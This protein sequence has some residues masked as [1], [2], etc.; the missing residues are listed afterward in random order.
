PTISAEQASE[1]ALANIMD[2]FFKGSAGRAAI[3]LLKRSEA[4]ISEEEKETIIRLIEASR[5]R[6]S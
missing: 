3:A 2:T 6:G 5:Q 1:S 4:D